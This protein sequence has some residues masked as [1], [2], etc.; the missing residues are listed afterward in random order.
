MHRIDGPGHV[1]G[2]FVS[3]DLALGRAPTVVTPEWLNAVQSELLGPIV[4]AGISPSKESN[5]QLTQA[6]QF[7]AAQVASS[8]L[9]AKGIGADLS[10]T[11]KYTGDLN[12][13]R[14]PGEYFYQMSNPNAPSGTANGVLKVW[15]EGPQWVYQMAQEAAAGTVYVRKYNNGTWTAWVRYLSNEEF[16]SSAT[17]GGWQ[18]LAS[19]MLVQWG[20]AAYNATDGAAGTPVS[21]PI[22]FPNACLQIVISD[23]DS[24]CGVFSARVTA[25]K[26]QFLVWAR[27]PTVANAPYT[28]YGARYI[29]IGY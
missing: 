7:L 18:R 15:R 22:A 28:S 8:A 2:A 26:T 6:I 16:S 13:L 4:A 29:A 1:G 19:G 3:E 24:A 9:Q 21:Y 27:N 10:V 11:N 20:T 14:D 23:S 12:A 5:L 25:S 17:S